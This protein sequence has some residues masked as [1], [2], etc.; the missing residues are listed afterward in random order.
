MWSDRR[1]VSELPPN[2]NHDQPR[3]VIAIPHV[4]P[5]SG[6]ANSSIGAGSSCDDK[7]ILFEYPPRVSIQMTAPRNTL[8]LVDLSEVL[9]HVAVQG[10]LPS[11]PTSHE[12]TRGLLLR[13]LR[14][15]EPT[16]SLAL[17]PSLEQHH[18]ASGYAHDRQWILELLEALGMRTWPCTDR[19]AAAALMSHVASKASE[20]GFRSIVLTSQPAL[21]HL[22]S[23]GVELCNPVTMR[24]ISDEEVRAAHG[25]G[26]DS[27]TDSLALQR[28][29]GIGQK[30][31]ARL[32]EAHG[33]ALAALAA[34]E[35]GTSHAHSLLRAGRSRVEDALRESRLKP[36]LDSLRPSDMAMDSRARAA[37]ERIRTTA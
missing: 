7:M 36:P 27:V 5:R 2:E 37:H 1:G 13:H 30:L 14:A 9:E 19:G 4:R 16:H 25:V 21:L 24:W 12:I 20:R 23:R 28:A 34:A 35:V 10:Y 22:L 8:V 32:L 15:L 26:P 6:C 31:A 33:D 11:D 17:L 29:D 18:H 3:P